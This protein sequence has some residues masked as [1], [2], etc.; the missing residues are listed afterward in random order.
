V[1]DPERC[2][3]TNGANEYVVTIPPPGEREELA[4]VENVSGS[5][6][7]T[8]FGGSG[9]TIFGRQGHPTIREAWRFEWVD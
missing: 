7:A 1:D 8:Q 6:L 3:G 4:A 5:N 9:Q 2:G